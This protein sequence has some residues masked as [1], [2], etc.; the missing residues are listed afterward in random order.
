MMR[1]YRYD[2]ESEIYVKKKLTV[3]EAIYGSCSFNVYLNR[4]KN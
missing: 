1:N 3:Y 2:N 4:I